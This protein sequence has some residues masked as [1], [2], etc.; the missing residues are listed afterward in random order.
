MAKDTKKMSVYLEPDFYNF[1]ESWV[2]MSGVGRSA[3]I[4]AA[5]QAFVGDL[6]ERYNERLRQLQEDNPH[7]EAI[8]VPATDTKATD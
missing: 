5:L 7:K 1:V 6:Q 3:F 2:K 4:K 8:D